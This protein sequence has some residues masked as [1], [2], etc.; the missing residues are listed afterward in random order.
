MLSELYCS[1]NFSLK[2]QTFSMLRA[3]EFLLQKFASDPNVQ[4][5]INSYYLPI[6]DWAKKQL[7]ST[8]L[9][10]AINGPQGCGKSTLCEAL[11]ETCHLLGLKA[12]TLSID[13][14]YLT[15]SAQIQLSKEFPNNPYLQ[16]RGSP[17]TH[18]IATGT[19]TLSQLKKGKSLLC[20]QYDK[21]A[22]GGLGDRA[23]ESKGKKVEGPLDILFFEGWML[24]FPPLP[25]FQIQ[26]PY[27]KQTN[28]FLAA[29]QSWNDLFDAFI[30][31]KPQNISD[32]IEWRV[33]A[34][35]K[36]KAEGKAG[37]SRQAI[38]EYIKKF[39]PAYTAY[40]PHIQESSLAKKPSLFFTL[41]KNRLPL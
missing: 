26:D 28:S 27:F 41:G 31:L 39:L 6:L 5:R 30:H 15:R 21:S 1:D 25:D 34:E 7:A 19:Q 13:D 14:F 38:E 16:Q 4:Q 2:W 20:P 40:L 29:Y 8:P 36:R 35:E 37:L 24:G 11:V 23:P 22:H 32:I 33:E 3:Q 12:A 10:I 17:G 18:D 9:F